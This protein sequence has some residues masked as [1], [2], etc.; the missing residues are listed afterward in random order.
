LTRYDLHPSQGRLQPR[1]VRNERSA[2]LQPL[3]SIGQTVFHV[4]RKLGL[5]GVVVSAMGSDAAEPYWETHLAAPLAAEPIVDPES[6]QITAVTSI[7]AVF[8]LEADGLDNQVALD[9]PTVALKPEELESPVTEVFQVKRRLLVM[10]GGPG[11]GQLPVFDPKEGRRFRWV[12]L[13]DP[14]AAPPIPLADDLLVPCRSGQVFLLDPRTGS[15]RT[16][17][18]QPTLPG[19]AQVAWSRPTPVGEGEFLLA[20]GHSGLYRIGIED[21]PKPHLAARAQVDLTEPIESPIAVVGNVAYAVD[22]SQSLLTF[23]LPKLT[24][25]GD[26]RPLGARSAWGPDR[27]GDC[28]LLA[29][30]DDQLYCL[31]AEGKIVWQIPLP[32]GPLAGRPLA[33]DAGYLLVAARGVIW[34]LDPATGRELAKAETGYPLATGAV[35]LGDG[36]LVGGH[37]GCLYK[38]PKP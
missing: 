7:G 38:L 16:E 14:L 1:S 15:P 28:V 32:Y 35:P 21:Q 9:Q 8:D 37:D 4:R 17:P 34:R 2:T 13:P 27:V 23:E 20:E 26:P 24:L 33:T 10:A 25:V 12:F 22:A 18:F 3:V 6:G 5:P 19:G 11:A 36:L 31:G 30:D 29:T